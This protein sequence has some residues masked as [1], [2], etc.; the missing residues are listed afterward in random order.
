M[1][2]YFRN[3]FWKWFEKYN[4]QYTQIYKRPKREAKFWSDEL[5][6]HLKAYCKGLE[7]VL[8][9][10]IEHRLTQLVITAGG[11]SRF[12]KKVET[13]VQKA[14]VIPGWQIT[15]LLQ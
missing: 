5:S 2:A 9:F 12:F 6:A 7:F 4:K 3:H 14:P 10:N 1:S 11:N 15:A 8:F 13:L